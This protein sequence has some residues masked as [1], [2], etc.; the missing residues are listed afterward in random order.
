MIN[1]ITAQNIKTLPLPQVWNIQKF[2]IKISEIPQEKLP[3]T[4]NFS[5]SFCNLTS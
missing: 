4:A 1:F 3:K 5:F 2:E